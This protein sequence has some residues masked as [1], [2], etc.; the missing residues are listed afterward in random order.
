MMGSAS[1][2]SSQ[3]SPLKIVHLGDDPEP[4]E[5]TSRDE[6]TD[7]GNA[8]RLVRRH[9]QDIRYCPAW[10]SWLLWNGMRW[11]RDD[12]GLI[13][14]LAKKTV[15]SIYVEAALA[16]NPSQRRLLADH[17][18]QSEGLA[19]ISAMKKLAES[20]QS[21]VVM[22][23]ELDSD[24]WLLNL[25]NGTLDLRSEELRPHQREDLI[26]KLAPVKYD[27]DAHCPLFMKFLA[28]IFNDNQGIIEYLQRCIGYC[29]T[30]DTSEQKLFMLIGDGANGK[31]TFLVTIQ[32]MLGD[33][34]QQTPSDLFAVKHDHG[35]SNAVARLESVRLAISTELEPGK[36]L[37]ESQI[38]QL[39]GGDRMV[40]R[41]LY[42][43]Y[44]EFT[45]QCKFLIAANHLPT[46]RGS[47]EGIWRRIVII[48][49]NTVIPEGERDK[50]LPAKLRQELSGI[51]IW[52]VKGCVAWQG[53]R[54]LVPSP[55]VVTA[56]NSYRAEMDVVRGFVEEACKP[57]E[58]AA[59]NATHLYESF[60]RWC[61]EGELEPVSQRELGS[62]L[63]RMGFKSRKKSGL[64]Q[65]LGLLP[66]SEYR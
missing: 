27:P 65:R 59:I 61:S 42:Q 22:P 52:A 66:K 11:Q 34:S 10:N 5:V 63:E 28:R 33:Y 51:L 12:R 36:A 54:D 40:A 39:T 6:N 49:F 4:R 15:I 57:Q 64:K 7:V 23:E 31:S 29:L 44:F 14:E 3:Q 8:A 25:E 41:M 58:G 38:K 60:R 53:K 56:T 35:P 62:R 19:R 37:A 13:I 45:P 21:I 17:A 9:R 32:W 1:P 2:S 46:V 48:P 43:E 47:D 50:D 24:P 18:K 30:G 20:D 26:T 16:D 55:E